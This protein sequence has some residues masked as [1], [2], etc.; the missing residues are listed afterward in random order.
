[1]KKI[2]ATKIYSK[3]VTVSLKKFRIMYAKPSE[4]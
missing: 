4:F 1:M 3:Y 2:K